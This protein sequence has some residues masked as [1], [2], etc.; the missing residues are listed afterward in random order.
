MTDD[1]VV[2][3]WRSN[4]F[5]VLNIDG[6]QRTVRGPAGGSAHLLGRRPSV[7]RRVPALHDQQ[8]QLRRPPHGDRPPIPVRHLKHYCR[9]INGC[10]N[11]RDSAL[12]N[13]ACHAATRLHLGSGRSMCNFNVCTAHCLS[14]AQLR[15]PGTRYPLLF[16]C[17]S[18]VRICIVPSRRT[19][20]TP[21]RRCWTAGPPRTRCA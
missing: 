4:I 1:P 15:T 6:Q 16:R 21:P 14:K 20:R 5:R 9:S 19:S 17:S 10:R 2:Q 7:R 8:R 3:R 11:G 13:R 12:P 18:L